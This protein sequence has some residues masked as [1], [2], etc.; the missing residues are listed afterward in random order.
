MKNTILSSVAAI[1]LA[2]PAMAG[3]NAAS[4]VTVPTHTWTGFYVGSSMT[5]TSSP[6]AFSLGE[7]VGTTQYFGYRQDLGKVVVGGEVG[8]GYSQGGQWRG[9]A[10]GAIGY[11]LGKFL[12]SINTGWTE[13]GVGGSSLT[14]GVGMEYKINTLHEVGFSVARKHKNGNITLSLRWARSF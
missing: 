2:V 1:L 8:I 13:A 11:D 4:A 5:S 3:D 9:S 7:R 10:Q 12:P 14:Y 6:G